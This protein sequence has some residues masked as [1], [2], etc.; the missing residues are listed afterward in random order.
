MLRITR[1][2]HSCAA[3]VSLSLVCFAT[4]ASPCSAQED[5]TSQFVR[6]FGYAA[7][8]DDFCFLDRQ[9]L[10]ADLLAVANQFRA[11]VGEDQLNIGVAKARRHLEQDQS[12]CGN[13]AAFVDRTATAE[14][15]ERVRADL[16]SIEQ[17][18]AEQ[19]IREEIAWCQPK[20]EQAAAFV[21]E[22]R[23]LTFTV[24]PEALRRCQTSLADVPYA[25]ELMLTIAETL[26]KL[27]KVEASAK[28]ER[29]RLASEAAA[30][31]T[32]EEE[33]RAAAEAEKVRQEDEARSVSRLQLEKKVA[34]DN[35][36]TGDKLTAVQFCVYRVS[37][38]NGPV[39]FTAEV[40]SDLELCVGALNPRE[41]ADALYFLREVEARQGR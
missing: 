5:P 32:A 4:M 23:S 41:E 3:K 24:L 15:F 11:V 30:R 19:V 29:E 25:A 17:S 16:A 40:V 18:R 39:K 26:R 20:I 8:V 31:Q 37:P 10:G 2:L 36:R 6:A 21:N 7:A 27:P 13:A 35:E 38:I 14:T 34:A 9:Y 12:A 1:A 22:G 28:V 33:K